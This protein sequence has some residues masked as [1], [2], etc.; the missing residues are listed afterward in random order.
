VAADPIANSL[1]IYSSAQP[2]A[3]SPEL[4]RT[5][6]GRC[7]I[8]GY[9][10]VRHERKMDLKAGRN[11][12]ISDVAGLIDPTTVSFLSLSDRTGRAS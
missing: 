9:A 10:V 7:G 1:T 3:I 5:V 8:P 11:A 4:Y 12:S 6:G 2:G